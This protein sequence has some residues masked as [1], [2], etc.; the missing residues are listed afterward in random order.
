MAYLTKIKESKLKINYLLSE[1]YLATWNKTR[2]FARPIDPKKL[3]KL[4]L[5]SPGIKELEETVKWVDI[6]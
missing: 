1:I 3:L 4:L 6:F 5:W 2:G